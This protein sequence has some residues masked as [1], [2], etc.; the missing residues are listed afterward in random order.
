MTQESS[1]AIEA[2]VQGI[3]SIV[4]LVALRLFT[5]EELETMVCGKPTIDIGASGGVQA[6]LLHSLPSGSLPR[7]LFSHLAARY[8]T[9]R[10]CPC[11][12]QCPRH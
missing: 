6:P 8:L 4:P 11:P 10:P 9:V 3:G 7:Q 1:K 2:I 12:R 5:G